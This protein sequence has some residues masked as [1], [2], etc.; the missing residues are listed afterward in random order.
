MAGAAI[1]RVRKAARARVPVPMKVILSCMM[2][3]FARCGVPRIKA[4]AVCQL[5]VLLLLH[6]TF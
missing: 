3:L 2:S 5:L 1:P 4:K 6:D